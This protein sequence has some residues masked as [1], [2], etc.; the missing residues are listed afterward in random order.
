MSNAKTLT[1]PASTPI[2]EF[3][4]NV[5][6]LN[7]GAMMEIADFMRAQGPAYRARVIERCAAIIGSIAETDA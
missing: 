2:A 1:P 4:A 5:A 7:N 3:L 6:Q